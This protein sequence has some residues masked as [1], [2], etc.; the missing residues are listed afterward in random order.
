MYLYNVYNI[1]VILI[2]EKIN[3]LK[4]SREGYM[5]GF[6]M[7]KRKEEMW[8]FFNFIFMEKIVI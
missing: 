6:R 3:S 1:Y 4:G 7:R 8:F 5:W 2:S